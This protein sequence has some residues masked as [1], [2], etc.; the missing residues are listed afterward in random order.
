M[1]L[2]VKQYETILHLLD[3]QTPRMAECHRKARKLLQFVY[4]T[5]SLKGDTGEVSVSGSGGNNVNATVETCR[6]MRVVIAF[7][8][9]SGTIW[10]KQMIGNSVLQL[11]RFICHA[12]RCQTTQEC[13]S[14]TMHL[15]WERWVLLIPRHTHCNTAVSF[16]CKESLHSQMCV[17]D[18]PIGSR[19]VA[20]EWQVSGRNLKRCYRWIMK[21]KSCCSANSFWWH[22][23]GR[24]V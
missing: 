4:K 15:W 12:W 6:Y 10:D 7:P 13:T 14:Y 20:G 19:W 8:Y 17:I 11:G 16:C 9:F 23:C 1:V 3:S 5:H 24:C 18:R 22:E 2:Q 21:E